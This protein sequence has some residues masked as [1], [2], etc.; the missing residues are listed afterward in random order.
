MNYKHDSP[1]VTVDIIIEVDGGIV[2]IS[3]KNEPLGWAL[4]GGFVDIGETTMNAAIR[5]A[6]EETGLK[7]TN[8]IQFHTYSD[9]ARDLR[10]HVITVVY[11]AQATGM[12]VAADDAKEAVVVDPCDS[13]TLDSDMTLCFDH[14]DIIYDYLNFRNDGR[15]PT[16]E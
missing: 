9:P 1:K 4:P 13:I 10:G 2:L 8:P 5:E 6:E 3:R 16:R 15:L 14:A 11:I 12:P 7:I